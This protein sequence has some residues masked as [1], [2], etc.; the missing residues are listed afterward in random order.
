MVSGMPEAA[1]L[2][3]WVDNKQRYYKEKTCYWHHSLKRWSQFPLGNWMPRQIRVSFTSRSRQPAREMFSRST[4]R[5]S[6]ER[7]DFLSWAL[8]S[9]PA[10]TS[11][12]RHAM[13]LLITAMWMAVRPA[14][15][16]QGQSWSWKA[17]H[18]MAK[19]DPMEGM[20]SSFSTPRV[21]T[22]HG[23]KRCCKSVVLHV[24]PQSACMFSGETEQINN[25]WINDAFYAQVSAFSSY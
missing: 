12:N 4:A 10:A 21:S 25:L 8:T 15:Q 22:P 5:C 20:L 7:P 9:A 24:N 19:L 11:S 6:A 2:E 3:P 16:A 14:A 1:T 18:K 17:A 13:L 23:L